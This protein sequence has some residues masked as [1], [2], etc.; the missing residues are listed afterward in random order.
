MTTDSPPTVGEI[1]DL[2]HVLGELRGRPMDPSLAYAMVVNAQRTEPEHRAFQEFL[3]GG[4]WSPTLTAYEDARRTLIEKHADR[5]EDGSLRLRPLGAGQQ[6]VVVL[7]EEMF[8]LELLD[9][10]GTWKERLLAAGKAR[11]AAIEE[12]AGNV[13]QVPL[14]RVS[15]RLL[16]SLGGAVTMDQM[17]RLLPM[18]EPSEE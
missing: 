13:A 17:R 12:I 5:E 3:A 11:E 18:I 6:E 7:D 2:H 16:A 10:Y 15:H 14:R 4:P 8:K 9:L 1:L